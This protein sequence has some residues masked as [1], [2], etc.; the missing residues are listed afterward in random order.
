MDR[1]NSDR[2]EKR[3]ILRAPRFRVWQA[4]AEA[5]EFGQW[6]GVKLASPFVAGQSVT[7]QVTHP[8]FEHI[9]FNLTVERMEPGQLLAW[10]WHVLIDTEG[11]RVS[12]PTTL[13]DDAP[14]QY[15]MGDG[16]WWRPQDDDGRYMGSI[17][18]RTALAQEPESVDGYLQLAALYRRNGQLEAAAEVLSRGLAATA[19]HFEL[20]TDLADLLTLVN[21]IPGL[22]RLRFLTSYPKYMSDKLIEAFASLDKLC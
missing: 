11:G 17:T 10:R 16:T 3:I 4:L 19:N 21:N 2:I 8:G 18:L 15:P 6:F 22:D 12:E 5:D 1:A 20:A 14:V 13:V 7:G 9:P